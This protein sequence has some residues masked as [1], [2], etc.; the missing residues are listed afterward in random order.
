MLRDGRRISAPI[1][2]FVELA[3]TLS[4]V[5]LV[6]LGDAM[7]R[8]GFCTIEDLV[9][10]VASI[11]PRRGVRMA[12]RAAALVRP[13]V[14]S[15][16]E[17]RLRLLLLLAGLPEPEAGYT[18]RDGLGGWIGEVDLAYAASKIAIEY[19]GDVHR[20]KR[21]RW[22]S[23]IAKVELLR[24][25]GWT[26]IVI[27]AEDLEGRPERILLRVQKALAG[28]GHLKVVTTFNPAWRQH[29]LPRWSRGLAEPPEDVHQPR[30]A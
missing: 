19:H 8:R 26:V 10:G 15:P 20:T 6:I 5:D 24:E 2:N 29:L 30:S 17:T 1:D 14:D 11:G 13:R 25:L 3:E 4:L 12:R 21:G 18:V 7:V 28:A 9:A 23:D 27:T 22:Q 16:M